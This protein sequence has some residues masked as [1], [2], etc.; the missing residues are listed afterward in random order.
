[1]TVVSREIPQNEWPAAL[2]EF[3]RDHRAWLATV[4][5]IDSAGSYHVEAIE[6]PL[7]AVTPEIAA[8]RVTG[9]SIQFQPDSHGRN[10]VHVDAPAH[11]RIER[12]D[13]G[14]A[15]ALE[16]EDKKGERTRIRFRATPP[17]EALDGMAPGE[18]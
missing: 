3:S 4:E 17:P 16:I 10:V 9:I 6:R 14:A 15:R 5:R 12:S 18:I 2:E 11:L 13:M 7:G 1:M 8:R